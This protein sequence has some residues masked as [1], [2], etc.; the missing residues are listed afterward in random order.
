LRRWN[1]RRYGFHTTEWSAFFS[2]MRYF[3][4]T[5]ER[6]A[7]DVWPRSNSASTAICRNNPTSV[8]WQ[9][10]SCLLRV[11]LR[12]KGPATGIPRGYAPEMIVDVLG[13]P[14]AFALGDKLLAAWPP[15]SAFPPP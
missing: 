15:G 11:A 10:S 3:E 7:G 5:Q 9:D 13:N 12:R 4:L 8:S 14:Y 2:P 6:T 1:D